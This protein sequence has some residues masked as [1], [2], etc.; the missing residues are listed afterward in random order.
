MYFP[1]SRRTLLRIRTWLEKRHGALAA[2]PQAAAGR[3]LLPPRPAGGSE[4]ARAGPGRGAA[5]PRDGQTRGGGARSSAAEGGGP[6]GGGARAERAPAA[7]AAALTCRTPA[8]ASA[9]CRSGG[10]WRRSAGSC[11]RRR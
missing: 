5:E 1:F 8:P 2:G 10:G 6:G 9:S 3:P 7:A 4:A 11:P